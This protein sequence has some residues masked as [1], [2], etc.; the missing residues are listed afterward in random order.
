MKIYGARSMLLTT[1]YNVRLTH[2]Y[3]I[4]DRGGVESIC[5]SVYV[6]MDP[7]SQ[8]DPP[9]KTKMLLNRIKR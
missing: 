1:F 4:S 9:L 3:V 2:L 7:Q 8:S 5:G 6:G